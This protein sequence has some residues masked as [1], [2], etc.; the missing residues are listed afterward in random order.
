MY[1]VERVSAKNLF[2]HRIVA[3]TFYGDI[4]D[5][6]Y[7]CHND[8]N[9]ENNAAHNLR[10]DTRESNMADCLLHGTANFGERNAAS[11]LTECQVAEMRES[12]ASGKIS[13][14]GIA[15]KYNVSPGHVGDILVGKRW[16][17]TFKEA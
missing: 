5:H 9:K 6:M 3:L 16:K 13:R 17:H 14:I 7:V 8:G 15:E 12:F 1:C 11:K 4:P 2:V 10:I